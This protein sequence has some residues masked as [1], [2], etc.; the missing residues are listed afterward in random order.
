MATRKKILLMVIMLFFAIANLFAAN[1]NA[2]YTVHNNM[3]FDIY[4]WYP[5]T[6]KIALK[7]STLR[8]DFTNQYSND[9]VYF[10]MEQGNATTT[11]TILDATQG[12]GQESG[13]LEYLVYH[14]DKQGTR[15]IN[16]G[17]MHQTQHTNILGALDKGTK[18]KDSTVVV[19]FYI[20]CGW[21][22]FIKDGHEYNVTGLGSL[23]DMPLQF[24]T[25][26]GNQIN[27]T[28]DNTLLI[29]GQPSV[30]VIG[31]APILSEDGNIIDVPLGEPEPTATPVVSLE[32]VTNPA[33]NVNTHIKIADL[34]GHWE[35]SNLVANSNILI[36][37]SSLDKTGFTLK[38]SSINETIPYTLNFVR[39][40]NQKNLIAIGGSDFSESLTT[41]N[42]PTNAK[43]FGYIEAKL[44]LTAAELNSKPAGSYTDTIVIKISTVE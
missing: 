27:P 26:S 22:S 15:M 1:Y 42:T 14:I 23:I 16:T 32:K 24:W 39:P 4:P 25:G 6:T 12:W 13:H 40:V 37:I 21:E 10:K 20:V 7:L 34:S 18:L 29:N 5:N 38:N 17:K 3:Y 33:L 2:T 36:N 11:V 19:E 8:I 43:P 28:T 31:D 30:P 35:A 44:A 9:N 41:A